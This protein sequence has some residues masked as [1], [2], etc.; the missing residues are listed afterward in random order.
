MATWKKLQ[1]VQG[2]PEQIRHIEIVVR[3][4]TAFVE[5][6]LA[7]RLNQRLCQIEHHGRSIMN[8]FF[9][10]L[11]LLAYLNSFSGTL[12]DST[13]ASH[14]K[15]F[16]VGKDARHM[17]A[18]STNFSA[19]GTRS[20]PE[21]RLGR[22]I[23]RSELRVAVSLVFFSICSSNANAIFSN[24]PTRFSSGE[25]QRSSSNCFL[26]MAPNT[27]PYASKRANLSL[28]VCIA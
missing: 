24:L 25:S 9:D 11:D 27:V 28:K 4:D 10:S 18:S 8:G 19:C 1:P 21:M 16:V 23:V 13:R 14:L 5:Y 3:L 12:Q 7:D 6:R 20:S 2:F 17:P 26:L 15:R 22:R